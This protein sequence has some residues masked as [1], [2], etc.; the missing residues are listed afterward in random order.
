MKRLNTA[1]QLIASCSEDVR[2]SFENLS[3]EIAHFIEIQSKRSY[4]NPLK[5]NQIIKIL[6]QYKA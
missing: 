5:A 6:K 2:V 4:K 3:K 1:I